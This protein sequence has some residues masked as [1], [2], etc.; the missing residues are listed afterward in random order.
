MPVLSWARTC[1]N[2]T[3]FSLEFIFC[4]LK[5]CTHGVDAEGEINFMSLLAALDFG[6]G[7]RASVALKTGRDFEELVVFALM[8]QHINGDPLDADSLANLSLFTLG[9]VLELPITEEV[10]VAPAIRQDMASEHKELVERYHATLQ[11]ISLRLKETGFSSLGRFV[12]H[13]DAAHGTVAPDWSSN[14][15]ANES[16]A[17]LIVRLSGLRNFSCTQCSAWS[18]RDAHTMSQNRRLSVLC[19]Q[20]CPPGFC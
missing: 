17:S 10:E 9:N 4:V 14:Q 12:L 2:A 6:D 19:R 7:W 1:M 13:P 11:N 15:S 5:F 16:A 20:S 8:S 3:R 18:S